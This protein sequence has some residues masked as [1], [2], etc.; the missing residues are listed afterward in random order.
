MRRAQRGSPEVFRSLWTL[1]LLG[2]GASSPQGSYFLGGLAG[3]YLENFM[4]GPPQRVLLMPAI[5]TGAMGICYMA[6]RRA[7]AGSAVAT[8]NNGERQRS[9]HFDDGHGWERSR[10]AAPDCR[11]GTSRE[12][13]A[14]IRRV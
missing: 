6:F 9:S 10:Y 5:C 12:V 4:L 8:H 14:A 11:I 3:V 7:A 13:Q 2:R 1:E